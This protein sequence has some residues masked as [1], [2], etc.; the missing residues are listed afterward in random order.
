MIRLN[1]RTRRIQHARSEVCN[2]MFDDASIEAIWS[3]FKLG[4]FYGMTVPALRQSLTSLMQKARRIFRS[5]HHL[6]FPNIE[7]VHLR[8]VCTAAFFHP[9]KQVLEIVFRHAFAQK[10]SSKHGSG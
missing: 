3:S 10:K 5:M 1:W 2:R 9:R 4:S 7:S 6:E 8:Q